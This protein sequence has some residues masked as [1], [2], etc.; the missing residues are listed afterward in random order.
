M[1]VE[2]GHIKPGMTAGA[3]REKYPM[4]KDYSYNC[5]QSALNNVRR[6]LGTEVEARE[7]QTGRGGKSGRIQSYS[8]LN[9]Y[10]DDD[11]DDDD[12]TYRMSKMSINDHDD[13]SYDTRTQQGAKSV[14]FDPYS[15]GRSIKSTAS[16]M[17]GV[18]SSS[19]G[20]HGHQHHREKGGTPPRSPAKQPKARPVPCSL[21]YIIDYWPDIRPKGRA[22]IQVHMLSLSKENMV[23]VTYR[24]STARNEFIVMI[25]VS[26]YFG[27]P[28]TAFNYYVLREMKPEDH[29][30][31]ISS[32][33]YHPKSTARRGYLSELRSK[34]PSVNTVMEFRIP[35][36]GQYS[37]DFASAK[38]GDP[39]FYGAKFVEYP[40]GSFHLHA[41]LVADTVEGNN[42]L[43]TNS[44]SMVLLPNNVPGSVS[45][46]SGGDEDDCSFMDVTVQSTVAAGSVGAAA[47]PST[48]AQGT[49]TMISPAG[50]TITPLVTKNHPLALFTTDDAATTFS[51]GA[52]NQDARSVKSRITVATTGTTSKAK[53]KL[54]ASPQKATTRSSSAF[55][56]ASQKAD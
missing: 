17:Q 15:S 16:R 53:R 44:A 19:S 48:F 5:F 7:Q 42:P 56:V 22:S 43:T 9:G 24:V 8:N 51:G 38:D 50:V 30:A 12:D 34:S 55:N 39:Y 49:T 11:D 32:L 23:N 46:P 37:L 3:A 20:G 27:Q 6:S 13:Y 28:D 36:R 47:S 45:V 4:F 1:L 33:Q 41:E 14:S 52:S 21:P 10:N 54:R 35:L 18:V 31:H 40:D 2:S 25:P 29:S 26:K